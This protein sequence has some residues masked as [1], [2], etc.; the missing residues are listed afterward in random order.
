M[1]AIVP[2]TEAWEASLT[3]QSAAV[4][5]DDLLLF[6]GVRVVNDVSIGTDVLGT[7]LKHVY[8]ARDGTTPNAAPTSGCVEGTPLEGFGSLCEE[9]A[10]V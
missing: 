3:Q 5:E 8:V 1:H 4:R 2:E 9:R 6:P 7:L 10:V